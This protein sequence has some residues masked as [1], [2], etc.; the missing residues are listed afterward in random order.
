[1]PIFVVRLSVGLAL[2]CLCFGLSQHAVPEQVHLALGQTEDAITVAWATSEESIAEVQ[3]GA[4][5]SGL[6][7]KAA[8]DSRVFTLDANRTW[9]THAATMTG[10]KLNTEYFY[11]VGSS[12]LWSEVR[13]FVNRRQ[14]A[15]YRHVILGDLGAACGFSVCDACTA[16]SEVCDSKTCAGKKLG[17]VSEIGKADMMLQVGDFA[18]DLDKNDGKTGDQFMRNIEQF[19]S[20]LPFMVSHGNHEDGTNSLAH[21]I[22]RFRSQPSNAIPAT[23]KTANGETT[24]TMYFS[25]DYGLIHYVSISTE[26]WFG[27]RDNKTTLATML[28]WL[29]KD[30]AATNKQRDVTPW[31]IVEGHRSIYCSC[32]GD[33]DSAAMTVR[34]DME[35]ILFEYGV[36][37][38]ING[39]EHNYERSYPLYQNKST[40][41]N[42]DPKAPIYIVSGAAGSV[43][44]H[45]PFTRPQPS[46]SAFRSNSFG[47]SVATV[48]NATHLHWQQ[49]QTDPTGF[50]KFLPKSW[51]YGHV[52]DDAWIVQHS[53]GPFNAASAPR[54]EACSPATACGQRQHDHWW[55]IL[56]LEDGSG[57]TSDEIIS[58][59]RRQKGEQWWSKTLGGLMEWTHQHLGGGGNSTWRPDGSII[60]ED[61]A[62]DGSSDGPPKL[63]SW[64]SSS[65]EHGI[66]LYV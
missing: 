15:P 14:G 31:I 18:Y 41:S 2:P 56:G 53:H 64:K 43:E 60:W 61:T 4:S 38:F 48:Y 16:H 6:T 27:V 1:M 8:A 11:R 39:H 30:L 47:Y 19:A 52:I 32:D 59:H 63:F 12:E 65:R 26:L 40:K 62:A 17:L 54:G 51:Y 46:W 33:C 37:F 36:D 22:E 25:W 9:Y 50:H 49:V 5:A 66:G 35:P 7:F 29:K 28:D 34:K 10:L 21:Y 23:F 3:W 55:P 44:L 58:E 24:N 20:R 13:S 57:R 45:E 42:I